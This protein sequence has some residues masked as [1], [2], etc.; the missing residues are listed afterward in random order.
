M[1]LC[2][3]VTIDIVP[4]TVRFPS[5][6][7]CN[8]RNLDTVILNTLNQI[9]INATDPVTWGNASSDPFINAYM[10]TVAKYY[11]LFQRINIR[12]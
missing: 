6:S 1:C 4:G 3:Q 11:P 12:Y 9:F 5:I 7:M 2:F 8:Q 10:A